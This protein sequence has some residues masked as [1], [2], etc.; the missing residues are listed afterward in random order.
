M[1]REE[2]AHRVLNVYGED[3]VEKV[4][5]AIAMAMEDGASSDGEAVEYLASAYTG[6][7]E[8][9]RCR[10]CEV[11]SVERSTPHLFFRG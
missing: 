8:S 3:S 6:E 4:D 2:R 7:Y 9:D 5:N 10:W 11:P 1:A